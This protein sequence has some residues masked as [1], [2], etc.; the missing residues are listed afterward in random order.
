MKEHTVI[1]AEIGECFNGDLNQAEQ[2]IR[3]AAA[4]GCDY[5]KF[6][7]LDREGISP[8]DPERDWFLSI[9]L[10][11]EELR[12]LIQYCKEHNIGFLCSPE[13]AGN[14]RTLK[15]LGCREVKIASTCAW[16]TELVDYIAEQFPIVFISTGMASLEEIDDLMPK[17]HRQEQVYLMHC[18]SE[19]PTG[20]LLEQRGLKALNP[21]D[22]RLKMMDMLTKRYPRAIVG[23]SDHTLG[24]TAPI[25]AVARGA[26]V[27]EKHITLDR[28]T[29]IKNYLERKQYLGTDHVL[30][31]L[32][33][34]L[35]EMVRGIREVE[36]MLTPDRWDRTEG[37]KIL[38]PFL[39]GRFSF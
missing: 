22:V 39:K 30:S 28:E 21:K 13:K 16:D 36:S 14:A 31:L 26:G 15:K 3:A 5:A 12:T 17:F 38:M 4:A 27:I 33:E 20:P 35:S 18:I 8:D 19:Y 32:P 29:P 9:A 7:T 2:L 34:E 37:E 11:E 24:L 6:Q 1:I 25:A 23:Y 10:E